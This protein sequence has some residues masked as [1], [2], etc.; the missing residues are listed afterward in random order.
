LLISDVGNICW[1]PISFSSP[2]GIAYYLPSLARLALA[3]PTGE[4][5]WYG[6][7][8]QLHLASG[9]EDNRLLLFCSPAQRK[10]VAALLEH[11]NASRE[12]LGERLTTIEE[13]EAT[14]VLWAKNT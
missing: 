14:R 12:M 8:L 2:E 13:M 5:G 6:D 10:A 7:T 9:G 4:Y 11:M 3:E 1:Q